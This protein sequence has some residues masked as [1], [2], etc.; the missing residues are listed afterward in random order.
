MERSKET[1]SGKTVTGLKAFNPFSIDVAKTVL[2][3]RFLSS[4]TN[5][6]RKYT[7]RRG[8]AA[9]DGY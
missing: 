6:A 1:R 5:M 3:T 8:G 7:R 4:S 9:L 2:K